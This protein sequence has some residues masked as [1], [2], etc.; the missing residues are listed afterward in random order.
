MDTV[1]IVPI[2]SMLRLLQK[3]LL[4][5]KIHSVLGTEANSCIHGLY[6]HVMDLLLNG[7]LELTIME[8]STN[9]TSKYGVGQLMATLKQDLVQLMLVQ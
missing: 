9:L 3:M 1:L 2:Q 5:C 6:S 8:I 7:S 4:Q